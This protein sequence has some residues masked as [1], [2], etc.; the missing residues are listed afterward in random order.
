MSVQD[1]VVKQYWARV[2]RAADSLKSVEIPDEGWI[3]TVRRAMNMS[4]AALGRLLGKSRA[5]VSQS[6][7]NE[8][9]G[10]V[11]LRTMQSIAD[12][13]GCRFVYAIIPEHSMEDLMR[14]HAR[15]VALEIVK[16]S[17][18]HMALEDQSLGKE[19]TQREVKR[20]TEDLI[21]DMPANFWDMYEK[22]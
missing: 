16:R 22:I 3:R 4:G 7:K 21:K 13:M 18:E 12:A 2:D 14:K 11:T 19:H 10:A 5:S 6:E 15:K 1:V 9:D 8:L 17:T 20:I